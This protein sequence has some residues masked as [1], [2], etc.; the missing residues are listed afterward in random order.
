MTISQN[1]QVREGIETVGKPRIIRLANQQSESETTSKTAQTASLSRKNLSASPA[2]IRSEKYTETHKHLQTAQ[3]GIDLP[4][5]ED[6]LEEEIIAV[7][8][9]VVSDAPPLFAAKPK[10]APA[11][12]PE[13]EQTQS[14]P[15]AVIVMHVI[16]NADHPYRG[17]ELLQ[18]ML[19]AGLRFGKWNIFHRHK[20]I[21][22]RG[23]IL[24]SLTSSV[25]PGTFDLAKISSFSSPGLT[26][27]MRVADVE[28]PTQTLEKLVSTA[29]QLAEELGGTVCDEKRQ[30]LTEQKLAVWRKNL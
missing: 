24:F 17:Y 2:F 29:Q 15:P 18:A 6:E 4:D 21:N 3:A 30:P 9:P 10:P 23:P 8:R 12:T 13:P 26:L 11:A 19:T 28:D 16:A 7:N 5:E 25:E 1:E 14:A 20:E 27:F 22:G